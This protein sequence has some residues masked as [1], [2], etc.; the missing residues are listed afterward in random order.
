LTQRESNQNASPGYQAGGFNRVAGPDW[1]SRMEAQGS[2][3]PEQW[4][5]ETN[6][7]DL[8][9]KQLATIDAAF[10]QWN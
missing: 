9:L 4:E 1:L 10:A 7:A 8:P 6:I 5:H 3:Q 2:R